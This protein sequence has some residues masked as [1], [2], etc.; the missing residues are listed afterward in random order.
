MEN[1]GSFGSIK[2]GLPRIITVSC[3]VDGIVA[4]RKK[5][6]NCGRRTAS[7]NWEAARPGLEYSVAKKSFSL[8]IWVANWFARVLELLNACTSGICSSVTVCRL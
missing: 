5:S 4:L 2:S 1:D 3:S 6:M 7:S 8:W